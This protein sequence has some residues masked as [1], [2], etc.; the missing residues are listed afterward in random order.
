[1]TWRIEYEEWYDMKTK[2]MI[3][4]TGEGYDMTNDIE[5]DLTNRI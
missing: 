3:N 4:K 1:M 2:K 5:Y